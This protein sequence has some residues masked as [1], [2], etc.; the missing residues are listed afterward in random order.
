MLDI[1]I[2]QRLIAAAR[3]SAAAV[4][5]VSF[6]VVTDDPD[7]AVMV[8][9]MLAKVLHPDRRFGEVLH[10]EA[11][12]GGIEVVLAGRPASRP[13]RSVV[14]GKSAHQTHGRAIA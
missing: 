6:L 11:V 7:D 12:E 8:A 14:L 3:A 2:D 9:P 5:G 4:E 13:F 10:V 1:P